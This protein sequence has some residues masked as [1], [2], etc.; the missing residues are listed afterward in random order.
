LDTR[1][2]RYANFDELMDY[3]RLSAMPVGRFVLEVHG[4]GRET[5]PASDALCAALQVINHL[6]DCGEDYRRL[7]RVYLPQAILEAHGATV[8]M[9]AAPRASP[10]LTGAIAQLARQADGLV[11]QGAAL[12]PQIADRRLALEIAAI[13][14]LARRLAGRLQR[15]DPLS[16]SARLGTFEFAWFGGLAVARGLARALFETST[17]RRRARA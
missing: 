1:K 10:A 12:L 13:H 14:G 5:W 15:R 2:K 8:E 7:D 16:G 4:E 6:Q 11:Q 17:E 9:M 3:C